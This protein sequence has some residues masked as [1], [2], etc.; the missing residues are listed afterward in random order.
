MNDIEQIPDAAWPQ[1]LREMVDLM[2]AYN[3]R[4]GMP[5]TEALIDAQQRIADFAN[6]FGGR[7]WYLPR[8]S[9]LEKALR[10]QRIFR[11]LGIKS[12][13]QLAAEHNLTETHIYDVA[14][15]QKRILLQKR[16]P[17]LFQSDN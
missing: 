12:A 11:E 10:D 2:C 4:Q 13:A 3:V 5:E 14:A 9:R 1:T 16:Q 15:Q 17:Q 8:G 7:R 6:Y